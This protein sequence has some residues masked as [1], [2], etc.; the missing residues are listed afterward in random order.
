MS[1]QQP[2]RRLTIPRRRHGP[3]Y[4]IAVA[5][6]WGAIAGVFFA[7]YLAHD[8]PDLDNL[9]P[10]G[11]AQ[12]IEVR[13]EDGGVIHKYGD[14][15]G[16]WLAFDEIP[17]SMVLA[18]LA[19]E[20][21]RFF[22]HTGVDARAI[23]RAFLANLRAG[24]VAQGGSTITQQLAK[25][26]FLKPDRTLKRKAQELLVALW[27]EQRFDKQQ[28]LSLYLN[29]VYFGAAAYGLDAAAR[30]YFGHSAARLSLSEAALLAGLLK[31]PSR[32]AP[33]RSLD[34]AQARTEDVLDA[35]LAAGFATED[36]VVKAKAA[37]AQLSA[38][39]LPGDGLYFA[40][41]AVEEVRRLT[42][43]RAKPLVVYTTLDPELQVKAERSI[44]D[45]LRASGGALKAEQ[46]A[47]VA[48]SPEGAVRAMVGGRRYAASQY[49]RAA[50][51]RR[52][53]GSAFKLMV[54]L[55]G[56][57]AGLA[58][59]QVFDDV[60]VTVE[61]WTPKN[62]S[63]KHLGPMTLADAFAG[64]INTI[65][66]QVSEAAGRERVVAMARRLGLQ[67]SIQPHPSLA[68][69]TSELSLIDLTSAYA[70]VANG[71]IAAR[72]Y[73][74]LEIRTADGALLYR[75][76]PPEPR[77]VLGTDTVRAISA[78][79]AK[80]IT[81]GTGRA[82]GLDRPAAGKTGTSQDFR[83]A[84]FVGF[85]SDLVAGVWFG[86]DDGTAMAG[87]TGGGLPARAWGRFMLAAHNARPARPL[88]ADL[89][90]DENGNKKS[91]LERLI[92]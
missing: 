85:T 67:G 33:T 7:G 23:V 74:I 62:Y 57:E 36:M 79:L 61:G 34:D 9:P 71:G 76:R 14:L 54:Y 90:T 25:N 91:W 46:G 6:V 2:E 83:D 16:R 13:G 31:A 82:A 17:Q 78:M 80:V 49:N 75:H 26:V 39:A 48:L 10:P 44:R 45:A 19:V 32:Y 72:A 58:P 43:E 22:R 21:R 38:D 55:A 30:K 8:L 63:G 77:Q 15:Y 20:D 11:R 68:L 50:Q 52:Q 4:W 69:G 47:L 27:L 84:F 73:G 53:P 86:N 59:D 65:A 92:D 28:I 29:R 12:T 1:P 56:L 3:I 35:M 88:L 5:F 64:S 66:V 24:R 42:E 41:W 37:P 51:A 18:V 89:E 70:T 60:P 40:D 81:N 87:V